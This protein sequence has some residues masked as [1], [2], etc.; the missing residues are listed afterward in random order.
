MSYERSHRFK[1]FCFAY[2]F[3]LVLFVCLLVV[4]IFVLYCFV[5]FC[6]KFEIH[7][8]PFYNN[9][10]ADIGNVKSLHIFLNNMLTFQQDRTIQAIDLR[11]LN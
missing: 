9:A 6:R 10:N 4:F 2:G 3:V 1:I 8:L 5:L 7:A 11:N